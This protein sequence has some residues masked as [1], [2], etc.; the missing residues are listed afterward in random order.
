MNVLITKLTM[1]KILFFAASLKSVKIYFYC[2][3]D[4]IYI[5]I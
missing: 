1:I 3:L 4:K 2:K 5:E